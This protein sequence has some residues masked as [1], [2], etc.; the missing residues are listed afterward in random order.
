M[1]KEEKI[2]N[3]N[4]Q[5]F[6]ELKRVETKELKNKQGESYYML[7]G[8]FQNKEKTNLVEFYFK[9]KNLYNELLEIPYLHIF[10]LY[11]DISV[12]YEGK[13]KLNPIACSL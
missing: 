7:S 5:S 10:K 13:F 2:T 6:I 12:D 11:Y 4:F 8:L 9:D 1:S 3:D